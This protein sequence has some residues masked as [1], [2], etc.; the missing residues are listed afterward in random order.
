MYISSSVNIHI[1][2]CIRSEVYPEV[3]LYSVFPNCFEEY[4]IA[5]HAYWK[6]ANHLSTRYTPTSK[7]RPQWENI[8]FSYRII[9][10][11]IGIKNIAFT[12]YTIMNVLDLSDYEM[13][14]L[15]V[16]PYDLYIIFYL[17]VTCT[18][19]WHMGV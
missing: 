14:V 4:C 2:Y 9:F 3:H 16:F 6:L 12:H 5:E 11:S 8:L 17:Y 7:G 18:R 13:G 15:M 10:Q 1:N 19:T